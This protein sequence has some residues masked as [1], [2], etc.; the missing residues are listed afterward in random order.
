MSAPIVIYGLPKNLEAALFEIYD[1]LREREVKFDEMWH[2][3]TE[4]NKKIW[5]WR[6]V[7]RA[8]GKT[9]RWHLG[10]RTAESF[11]ELFGQFAHL[12]QCIFR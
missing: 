4:K 9:W 8:T 11:G 6:A 1:A 10:D 5:I 7:D 12:D 2:F 3:I